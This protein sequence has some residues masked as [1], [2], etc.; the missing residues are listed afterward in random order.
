MNLVPNQTN[1]KRTRR[2]QKEEEKASKTKK[3]YETIQIWS[4]LALL[5]MRLATQPLPVGKRRLSPST[6]PRWPHAAMMTPPSAAM[7]PPSMNSNAYPTRSVSTLRRPSKIRTAASPMTRTLMNIKRPESKLI[8]SL[9]LFIG[10]C[11][12]VRALSEA[13]W[14]RSITR[15]I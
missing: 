12:T 9:K 4:T 8:K 14:G 7:S 6:H 10:G 1:K 3:R 11:K 5:R 2:E 15:T 13:A